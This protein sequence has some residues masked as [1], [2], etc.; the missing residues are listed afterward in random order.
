MLMEIT[1]LV[2]PSW[3]TLAVQ[4]QACSCW[5]CCTVLSFLCGGSPQR[6]RNL[7]WAALYF[8]SQLCTCVHTRD[9]IPHV[10]EWAWSTAHMQSIF[11]LHAHAVLSDAQN[12]NISTDWSGLL[13]YADSRCFSQKLWN[14]LIF[15]WAVAAEQEWQEYRSTLRKEMCLFIPTST[16]ELKES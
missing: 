13:F 5:H 15:H 7:L 8:V 11:C 2:L 1:L 16:T 6:S 10:E 14:N 3:T 9:S 4:V 12:V